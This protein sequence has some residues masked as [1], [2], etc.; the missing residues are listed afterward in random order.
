MG[1]EVRNKKISTTNTSISYLPLQQKTKPPRLEEEEL[2]S[3]E[4]TNKQNTHEETNKQTKTK[5]EGVQ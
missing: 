3:D 4:E 1:I 5:L 2:Y